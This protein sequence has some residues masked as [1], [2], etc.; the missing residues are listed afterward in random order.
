MAQ[1]RV[2]HIPALLERHAEELEFL[3]GQRRAALTSSRLTLR[4]YLHLTERIAAHTQGLLAVPDALPERLGSRLDADERDVVF[5]GA[6]PL[7][8]LGDPALAAR[9]REAFSAAEGPRQEGLRD[10][11]GAMPFV[12]GA[13]DAL[14]AEFETAPASRA[15]AAAVV[16]ANQRAL[17]SAAPRLSALLLDEDPAVLALAWRVAA[18]VDPASA[19]GPPVR[20]YREGLLHASPDVRHGALRCAVWTGQPWTLGALRKLADTGDPVALEWLA[21]VGTEEDLPRIRE[22]A[23]RIEIPEPRFELL[24]RFGH[25]AVLDDLV[26]AMSDL[27]VAVSSA[28]GEAFIQMTGFD[29]RAARKTVPVAEDADEFER[30]FA[31]LVWVPDAAKAQAHVRQHQAHYRARTKWRCAVDVS[32]GCTLAAL[33]TVDLQARWDACGRAALLGKP[34]SLPP[35]I[36]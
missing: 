13:L 11:L 31:P 15:V 7:L 23:A 19:G 24:A 16:L 8:G 21:A 35:P 27:D 1:P 3:A 32:P 30:E 22:A 6:A 33:A 10:A 28:A 5:S 18:L 25:P 29:V 14:R 34:L 17:E 9:I 12:P 26:Q 2:R 20:S 36:H 4:D